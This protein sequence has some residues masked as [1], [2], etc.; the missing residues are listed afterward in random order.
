V[1]TYAVAQ[2]L[3]SQETVHKVAPLVVGE[4]E[5]MVVAKAE[6]HYMILVGSMH[7][8]AVVLV[9][10]SKARWDIPF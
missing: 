7:H 9:V 2:A 5:M 10:G 4:V 6:K 3:G 1:W 8:L